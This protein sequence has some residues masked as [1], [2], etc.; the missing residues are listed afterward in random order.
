MVEYESLMTWSVCRSRQCCQPG[1]RFTRPSSVVVWQSPPDPLHGNLCMLQMWFR[2][3]NAD[4]WNHYVREWSDSPRSS[5]VGNDAGLVSIYQQ[6]QYVA[7]LVRWL[8]TRCTRPRDSSRSKRQ[9]MTAITTR[10]RATILY[11][12]TTLYQLKQ[13]YPFVQT[14]KQSKSNNVFNVSST[15]QSL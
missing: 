6:I 2:T 5:T 11:E 1:S 9:P 10:V 15:T 12:T 8:F 14:S 4:V 7:V 3:P 13:P